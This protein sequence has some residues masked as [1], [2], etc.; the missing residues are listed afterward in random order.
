MINKDAKELFGMVPHG[1]AVIIVQKDKP[2]RTLKS[3]DIGSDVLMLQKALREL[4]YFHDWTSGKFGDNLKRSV[5]KYQ[6][7]NNFKMTG[8]V[9]KALYDNIMQEYEYKLKSKEN[10]NDF[11]H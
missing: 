6:K 4:G 9:G 3:G 7:A 5:I 8:T 10:Q 1:T 2:F 11:V